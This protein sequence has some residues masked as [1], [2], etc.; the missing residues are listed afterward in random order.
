MRLFF[1]LGFG[2]GA[3]PSGDVSFTVERKGSLL[4]SD[5]AHQPCKV[6]T[7]S[8]ERAV[9]ND[10]LAAVKGFVLPLILDLDAG[11]RLQGRSIL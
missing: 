7:P 11:Y 8:E 1:V 3:E 9:K 4:I 6:R 10:M 5:D 2:D